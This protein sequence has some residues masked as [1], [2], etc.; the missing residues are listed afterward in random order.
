MN[1]LQ[2]NVQKGFTLIELMIVVAIIAFLAAVA[3][4]AYETYVVRAK[5][6]EVILAGSACRT[7]ITET[8]QIAKQGPAAGKWGCEKAGTE[9]SQYVDA[10]KTNANG[11]IQ[12][13]AKGIHKDVDLKTVILQPFLDANTIMRAT[14]TG[15]LGKQVYSWKCGPEIDDVSEPVNSWPVNY[16]PGSCRTTMT[17]DGAFS[18]PL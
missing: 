2:K 1:K 15:G 9:I 3:L 7:L 17:A 11:A 13:T 18:G 4:P 10:I 6:S 12:V 8:Y 16:L 5:V 14:S